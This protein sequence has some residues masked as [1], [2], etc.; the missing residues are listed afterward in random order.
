MSSKL[1]RM[2][3]FEEDFIAICLASVEKDSDRKLDTEVKK[4]MAASL[5]FPIENGDFRL[6]C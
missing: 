1:P 4:S 3:A 6:P 5:Y 2:D